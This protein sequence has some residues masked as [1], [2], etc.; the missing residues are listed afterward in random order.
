MR[1]TTR[2]AK[3]S[4]SILLCAFILHS[5]SF[6]GIA[7]PHYVQVGTLPVPTASERAEVWDAATGSLF[8]FP[9]YNSN[10]LT[11]V[12]VSHPSTNDNFTW[13]QT[14]SFLPAPTTYCVRASS[15]SSHLS[16]CGT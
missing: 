2:N 3:T 11:V 15:D 8:S 13:T 14:T 5:L 4:L 10:D 6:S 1:T 7:Q 16:F 9:Y 12:Y